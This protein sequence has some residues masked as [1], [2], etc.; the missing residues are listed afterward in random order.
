MPKQPKKSRKAS[1]AVF[2]VLLIVLITFVAGILFHTFV[3]ENI[4]FAIETFTTQMTG[5]LLNSFTINSTH[6]IAFLTNTGSQII[7]I[8]SAYVN[9]IVTAMVNLVKIAPNAIGSVILTGNFLPGN[10]Y[11]VKL[12][13]IFNTEVTFQATF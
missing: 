10:T 6:I 4:N 13:N 2:G 5:L 7:E 12:A 9:G 11:D 3:M 1:T 8:T